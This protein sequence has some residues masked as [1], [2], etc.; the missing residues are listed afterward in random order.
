MFLIAILTA[1]ICRDLNIIG[2]PVRFRITQVQISSQSPSEYYQQAARIEA[3]L[4]LFTGTF[5]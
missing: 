5:R 1:E 3:N 2:I 4:V